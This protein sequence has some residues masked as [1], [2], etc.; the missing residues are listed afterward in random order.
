MFHIVI[1]IVD[2]MAD[3]YKL[4]VCLLG[5]L[6][7]KSDWFFL[8]FFDLLFSFTMMYLHTKLSFLKVKIQNF[9][10]EIQKQR[11]IWIWALP[12]VFNS[13][14][15]KVGL[16]KNDEKCFLRQVKSSFRSQDIYV[17]VLTFRVC[18][19]NGLVRKIRLISKFMTSQ[20]G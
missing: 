20:P 17:F 11:T 5:K 19:K 16:P 12:Q 2:F 13:Q 9:N 18:G 4:S 8:F 7:I 14:S 10:T 1:S 6:L 3:F 15:L